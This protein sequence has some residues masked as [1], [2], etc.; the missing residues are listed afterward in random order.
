MSAMP[1]GGMADDPLTR[2]VILR[3]LCAWVVDALL[4]GVLMVTAKIGLLLVG[5]FTLGLGLPLLGLLPLLPVAYIALW[6]GSPATATPGQALL[7]LRV[8]RSTDLG[9][10][11]PAQVVIFTLGYCLTVAAGVIWL[12]VALLTARRRTLH[13]L[14]SGLLVVREQALTISPASWNMRRGFGAT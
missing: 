11:R 6:I 5:L 8:V 10:P 7:G 14:V 12:G 13:D 4:V 1:P 9:R 2:G 3:R